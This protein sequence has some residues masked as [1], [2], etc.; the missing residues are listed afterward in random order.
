MSTCWKC[1]R[2]VG[3]G[4]TECE[5][6]CAIQDKQLQAIAAKMNN[7]VLIDWSKLKTIEDVKLM[8]SVLHA[9]SAVD[10]RSDAYQTLKRFTKEGE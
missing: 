7:L 1:G 9:G 5:Y 2:D 6:G 3:E 8:L 10:R 4:Q